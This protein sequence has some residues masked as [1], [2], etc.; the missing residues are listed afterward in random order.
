MVLE[1]PTNSTVWIQETFSH[2]VYLQES[3][4]SRGDYVASLALARDA[5]G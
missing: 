3:V 2:E 1:G 5:Q 4:I